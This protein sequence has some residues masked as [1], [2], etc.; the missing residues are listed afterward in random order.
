MNV[1]WD[2]VQEVVPKH[3]YREGDTPFQTLPRAAISNGKP[4]HLFALNLVQM[5]EILNENVP[6]GVYQWFKNLFWDGLNHKASVWM[7]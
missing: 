4:F 5:V 1:G 6:I 3:R 2:T 7:V